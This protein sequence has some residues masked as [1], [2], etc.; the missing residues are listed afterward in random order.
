MKLS[1]R[2]KSK[3]VQDQRG[4]TAAY[5]TGAI[6]QRV[7]ARRGKDYMDSLKSGAKGPRVKFPKPRIK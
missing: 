3:N 1:G 5:G 7:T 6:G 2:R 4:P